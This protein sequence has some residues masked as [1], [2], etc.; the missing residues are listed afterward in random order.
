MRRR[1][2]PVLLIAAAAAIVFAPAGGM[3]Q[4]LPQPPVGFKPPPPPPPAP[5]RPYKPVTITPAGPFTDPAF[6]AF[7]KQLADAVAHKDRAAL[8]KLIVSHDFFWIQDSNKAD[9][10]KP[11]IDNL[12]AAIGLDSPHGAGWDILAHDAQEPTLAELPQDKGLFCAPAPPTF[13]PNAFQALFEQTDTQPDDWG[14]PTG[15][16]TDVRAAAKPDA[17]V[18][19]KLGAYFVRVLPDSAPASAGAPSF[20]HIALPD[21]K[22]GFIPADALVP[23]ASDQICY[24]K[25]DNAW[26]IAGYVG[27]V[28]Q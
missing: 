17:P 5:V 23:L 26:K 25:E 18:V 11:G 21:G 13:D 8:A 10:N 14:Y 22:T 4:D 9:P 19:E 15:S 27:G 16:G 1:F 2:V 24:A 3:A 20:L 28:S 6:V 12:A 7:R